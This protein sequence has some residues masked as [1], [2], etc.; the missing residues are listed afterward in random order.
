MENSAN[1]MFDFVTAMTHC[2]SPQHVLSALQ[3]VIERYGFERHAITGLPAAHERLEDHVIAHKWPE[4]WLSIYNTL[5]YVRIDPVVRLARCSN[6]GFQWSGSF[7]K[8]ALKPKVRR[9]LMDASEFGLVDGFT[10]PI[11]N[12]D[13]SQSLVSFSGQRVEM[14]IE[15]RT[16]LQVITYYAFQT[17]RQFRCEPKLDVSSVD[18]TL[19]ERECVAW[20]AEGKS[21]WEIGQILGRSQKTIQHMVGN[22]SR[23]LNVVNR[24][25]LVAQAFR[26][27]LIQ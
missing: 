21:N 1:L 16:A 11:H 17:L 4:E 2:S 23:K 10:V 26:G 18:L 13:G 5:N 7:G 6:T 22:A 9:I 24:A 15:D 27:R 20:V 14:N 19:R 8:A 3:H 12:A 25:Q